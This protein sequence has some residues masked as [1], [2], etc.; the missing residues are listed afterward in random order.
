MF[1]CDFSA[2]GVL[3][4][5]LEDQGDIQIIDVGIKFSNSS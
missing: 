1:L 2:L 3:K 5:G 4:I